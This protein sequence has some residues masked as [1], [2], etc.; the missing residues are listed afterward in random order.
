MSPNGVLYASMISNLHTYKKKSKKIKNSWLSEV[1]WEN[2]RIKVKKYYVNFIKNTSDLKKKFKNFKI[3]FVGQ[4][5]HQLDY[6]ETN[7]HHYTIICQ[8]K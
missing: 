6:N 7:S 2:G 3:I 5:E 1:N 8:K 4:Y